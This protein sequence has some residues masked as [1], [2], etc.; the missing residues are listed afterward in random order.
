MQ[1]PASVERQNKN[2][3]VEALFFMCMGSVQRGEVIASPINCGYPDIF[4]TEPL[5]THDAIW[6]SK[7]RSFRLTVLNPPC[8]LRIRFLKL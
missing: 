4:G 5:H 2:E 3:I 7:A 1:E 6:T 8:K